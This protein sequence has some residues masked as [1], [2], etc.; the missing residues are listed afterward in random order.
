M[1]LGLFLDEVVV[2]TV[3]YEILKENDSLPLRGLTTSVCESFYT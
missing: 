2:N 3:D 1:P